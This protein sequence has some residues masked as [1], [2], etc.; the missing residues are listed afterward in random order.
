MTEAE[1]LERKENKTHTEIVS[2]LKLRLEADHPKPEAKLM[3][4][5]ETAGTFRRV[6]M[7]GLTGADLGKLCDAAEA[8]VSIPVCES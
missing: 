1:Y 2:Y 8:G 3:I 4:V 5:Y 7:R 6:L